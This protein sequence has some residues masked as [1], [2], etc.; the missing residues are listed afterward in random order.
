[1]VQFDAIWDTGATASVITQGVIDACGLT[2]T[3]IA[4]VHHVKGSSLAETYLVNIGLPNAVG[5]S[6]VRVTKG[7]F[8]GGDILIGM[9][10]IGTG[11][12]T[13][14][15]FDGFTKFSFRY[16]SVGHI[17]FVAD[18]KT[19]QFQHGGNSRSKSRRAK[20]SSKKN[21]ANRQKKR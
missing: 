20:T 13:V 14:T 6:A 15:N 5:Y 12:F 8:V 11:D 3:G 9:D 4:R 1:M 21:K 19:P 10:I 2:P 7:E 16:P 17:D 18:I